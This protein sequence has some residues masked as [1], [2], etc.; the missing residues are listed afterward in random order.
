MLLHVV[1]CLLNAATCRVV[2]EYC[3]WVVCALNAATCGR[4]ALNTATCH[5]FVECFYL[6]S[7]VG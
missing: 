7:C 1:V 3:Y 6:W 2:V 4:V 5:V